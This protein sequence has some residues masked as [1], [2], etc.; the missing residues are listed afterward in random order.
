MNREI[1]YHTN[2]IATI[3]QSPER[4]QVLVKATNVGTV[5]E[6][7]AKTDGWFHI[8]ITTHT[9]I[10]D[11]FGNNV[12]ISSTYPECLYLSAKVNEN[13]KIERI[14]LRDGTALVVDRAV[15]YIDTNVEA[16][17]FLSQKEQGQKLFA[18]L[19]ISIFVRFLTGEPHGRVEFRSAGARLRIVGP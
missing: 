10:A 13:A 6:Q 4:A 17:L 8:P 7:S 18:G 19:A 1:D 5:V 14:H 11:I 9:F 2:G 3:L 15:N 12:T 16:T